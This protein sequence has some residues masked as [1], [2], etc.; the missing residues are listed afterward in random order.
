VIWRQA[1][2]A[3][4]GHRWSVVVEEDFGSVGGGFRG[5]EGGRRWLFYAAGRAD[6]APIFMLR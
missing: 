3:H 6:P 5:R 4:G 1:K 2:A